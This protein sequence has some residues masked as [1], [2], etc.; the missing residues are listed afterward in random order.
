MDRSINLFVI[1]SKK[2]FKIVDLS[3]WVG[4]VFIGNRKHIDIIQE[5]QEI[6]RFTGIYFLLGKDLETNENYL[7]IGE[8]D[9]VAKRI[10]QHSKN[11]NK[12]WF[13][14]FIIFTSKDNSLTKAHVKYLEKSLYELAS[15]NLTTIKLKNNNH[16]SG[17]NLLEHDIAYMKEFKNDMIFILNNLGI[18]N[19]VKT[20]EE[21]NTKTNQNS[22]FY[23]PLTKDRTDKDGGILS[24]KMIITDNGYLVLKDS[25]VESAERA[26]SF[27]KHVYY[28]LRKKLEKE[29]LFIKSDIAGVLKTKENI[30]FDSCSAAAAVIKN[31]ATNGRIEWKLKNGTTLDSF[32]R[33]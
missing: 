19:F 15:Q 31:R 26:P 6:S 29:G 33:I 32:E 21:E 18:L 28:K 25:Y 23:L 2:N 8:A 16:P 27:K 3:N 11:K 10:K 1:E 17:S 12:N 20:K 22:I 7:Y 9:D 4:K 14:D 24:A 5:I 13:E 30:P